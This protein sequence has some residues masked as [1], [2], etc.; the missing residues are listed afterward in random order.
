MCR[1]PLAARVTCIIAFHGRCLPFQ[2]TY[3]CVFPYTATHSLSCVHPIKR[4]QPVW[5]WHC[6]T[7]HVNLCG[8][9]RFDL[10]VCVSMHAG[11]RLLFAVR[12]SLPAD[13]GVRG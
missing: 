6:D 10:H 2:N 1:L 9:T 7:S 13:D 4:T 5:R 8:A 12:I 3:W 11:I